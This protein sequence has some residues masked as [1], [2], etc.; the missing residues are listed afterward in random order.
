MFLKFSRDTYAH[1]EECC[2]L[3]LLEIL[4]YL[5]FQLSSLTELA[6]QIFPLVNYFLTVVYLII[7]QEIFM[8]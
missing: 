6:T 1:F 4:L 3:I 2:F 5:Q 7:D 8:S